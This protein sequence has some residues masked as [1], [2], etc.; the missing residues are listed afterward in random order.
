VSGGVVV[1]GPMVSGGLVG[2]VV[3]GLCV[4][5]VRLT[6][7]VGFAVVVVVG[8]VVV[9]VRTVVVVGSDVVVVACVVVVV[10]GAVVDVVR[11]IVVVVG[12]VVAVV[13]TVGSSVPSPRRARNAPIPA[14]ARSMIAK[15]TRTIVRFR[16]VG[17]G[18]VAPRM[19]AL[20][21]TPR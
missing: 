4:V 11:A 16:L 18:G 21:G 20:A 6:V 13:E 15:A 17:R 8:A 19:A 10:G 7:V 5:V 2:C 14:A 1:P 9:V 3:V 12:A